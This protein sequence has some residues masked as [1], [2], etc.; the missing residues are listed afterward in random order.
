MLFFLPSVVEAGA[1]GDG[2]IVVAIGVVSPSIAVEVIAKVIASAD[3]KSYQGIIMIGIYLVHAAY[4]Y[5]IAVGH[6]AD[7]ARSYIDF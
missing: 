4:S 6:C 1:E 3:F 2:I 5:Y 7:D